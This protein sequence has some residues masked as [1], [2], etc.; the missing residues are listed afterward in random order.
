MLRNNFRG[1]FGTALQR[2]APTTN[3]QSNVITL[4]TGKRKRITGLS[5]SAM[6]IDATRWAEKLFGC[7][8]IVKETI[9]PS[10]FFDPISGDSASLAAAGATDFTNLSV[11]FHAQYFGQGFFDFNVGTGIEAGANETL[12]V[13]Q[14]PLYDAAGFPANPSKGSIAACQ[15]LL[16]V[17]GYYVIE[18]DQQKERYGLR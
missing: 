9:D 16:N 12:T 4:R 7:L 3:F 5:V 11:I 6:L 2:F 15:A 13:V 1:D 8:F 14:T 17:Q 10:A 18:N